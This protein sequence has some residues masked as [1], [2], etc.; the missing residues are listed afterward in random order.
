MYL[1]DQCNV[2]KRYLYDYQLSYHKVVYK[3][4][5][6]FARYLGDQGLDLK[7]EMTQ[8]QNRRILKISGPEPLLKKYIFTVLKIK[9]PTNTIIILLNLN[10]L[11]D[12]LNRY[13]FI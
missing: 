9:K 4:L 7:F 12:K 8:Y 1:N 13:T 6:K 5:K 10:N 11:N 2:I 3:R